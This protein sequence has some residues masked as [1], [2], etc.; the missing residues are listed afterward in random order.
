MFFRWLTRRKRQKRAAQPF[1]S[2]WVHV[3]RHNLRL[4]GTLEAEEQARVREYVQVFVAEKH[5]E[6][7][8][9]LEMSDEVRVTVAAQVAILVLGFPE[10]EYFDHVLSILVYPQAYVAQGRTVAPAG[11]VLEGDSARQGEAWY[12]GPVVL[13]WPDVLAGGRQT[14]GAHNLIFHEFAHQ[15]DMLNG[16][17]ADGAPP[18]S[19]EAQQRRWAEVMN[20]HYAELVAAC[21]HGHAALL[22]CYGATSVS[23]FFAVVTETFFQ[24]PAALQH[25]HPALYEIL[26]DYYRQDPASRLPG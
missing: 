3:L 5:W 24:R 19:T 15:L 11:I 10:P 8:G 14:S 22:D 4:Y 6:G 18:I 23:E 2:D 25:Q 21:E 26:R 1:P 20:A 16:R 9:G 12:R 7:C 13:S 17:V